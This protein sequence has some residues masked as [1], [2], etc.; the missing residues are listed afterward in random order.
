M[1]TELPPAPRYGE[2]SVADLLPSVLT[3]LGVPGHADV[4]GLGP[5]E[6]VVVLVVDG[7][8]WS[9]LRT[10][11]EVAPTLAEHATRRLDAVFPATTAASLSS[12]AT[13]RPPGEHGLVGYATALRGEE[14]PFNLLHWRV[15][16]QAGGRD[17]RDEIVPER[18]QPDATAFERAVAGGVATSVLLSPDFVDSG[19]TRAA[20]RGGRIMVV[21]ELSG[22]LEAAAQA[23]TG[24]APR[25]VYAYHG[26][27]DREG[28]H[29]GP[30]SP[31]WREALAATD[32]ALAGAAGA[33]PPGTTVLVT[34]DHGMVPAPASEVVE[35]ADR[36]ALAEG[37]RVLAGE[38]RMRHVF[39]LP[40]RTDDVADRWR[41]ALG[42]RARVLQRAEA[43][44]RGLFGPVVLPR[45][46]P[47]IGDVLAI[48]RRGTLV[49]R[50]VDPRGGRLA[51]H[52]GALDRTEIEVPLI[53]LADRLR[54]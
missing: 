16:L 9:D 34:A 10:H 42:D 44:E 24:P 13:G 47:L 48:A 36:P 53:V 32:E 1:T 45:V 23:A 2:A 18:F 5:L 52:H 21:E 3:G 14:Q 30:G 50:D 54:R 46:R 40:G 11:G 38:P 39:T 27:V 19:L 12:I 29:H 51:G 8:G 22:A 26:A 4:L 43:I 37:V 6:R 15:G 28:H 7:L 33:M 31:Q 41:D 35:L 17:V 49:H 20:L 25:L